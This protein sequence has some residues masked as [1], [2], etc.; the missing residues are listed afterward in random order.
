MTRRIDQV[1]IEVLQKGE[2]MGSFLPIFLKGG[3]NCY[4]ANLRGK[5]WD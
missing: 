4:F 5:K 3:Q 1:K 2:N